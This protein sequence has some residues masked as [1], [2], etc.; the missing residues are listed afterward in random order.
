MLINASVAETLG[1]IKANVSGGVA[2]TCE[3]FSRLVP[4]ESTFQEVNL[5]VVS[6]GELQRT[7]LFDVGGNLGYHRIQVQGVNEPLVFPHCS[8]S[9]KE[10]SCVGYRKLHAILSRLFFFSSWFSTLVWRADTAR[11]N[12]RRKTCIF[13]MKR[14]MAIH[15]DTFQLMLCTVHG[16]ISLPNGN[17]PCRETRTHTSKVTS[18]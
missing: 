11:S 16:C 12:L 10:R 14:A 17:S 13:C 4:F 15:K 18:W 3:K 5:H 1:E 6:P 7:T 8:C 9:E 2:T